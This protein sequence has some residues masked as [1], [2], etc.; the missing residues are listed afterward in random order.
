MKTNFASRLEDDLLLT[1]LIVSFRP[2]RKWIMV[3]PQGQK[4]APRHSSGLNVSPP[5]PP[6]PP[7]HNQRAVG[8]ALPER[9]RGFW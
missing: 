2:G 1:A 8:S 7:R 3:R 6:P 4:P 5:P 9:S